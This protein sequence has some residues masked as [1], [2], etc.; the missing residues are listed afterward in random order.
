MEALA[1][2]PQIA[3]DRLST[4]CPDASIAPRMTRSFGPAQTVPV[5]KTP[6]PPHP[7]GGSCAPADTTHQPSPALSLEHL[8]AIALARQ[9]ARKITRA[10]T[11]AAFSG[12]TMA[13]FAFLTILSG[14]F[15][16][17]ELPELF[18]GLGLAAVAYAEL[19]GSKKLRA[20]DLAAPRWLGFNQ[21]TLGGLLLLYG[22]WG[23]FQALV[24]PSPYESYLAGG[25]QVAELLEPIDRLNRIVMVAFYATV[26]CVGVT[27]PACGSVY[28]FT[29]RR[30]M[31]SYL[32]NTPKWIVE[33]LRIATS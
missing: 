27:A 30:H 13:C 8:Q 31:V 11:I 32:A 22:G 9:Q 19:R 28:Y 2:P 16:L 15:S 20:F 33:T 26:L 7:G 12:W 3:D 5:H 6:G 18:L 23:L 29:R 1:G 21:M 4:Q 10:A 24:A 17:P 14:L 25:G